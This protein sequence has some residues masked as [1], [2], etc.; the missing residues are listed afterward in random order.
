MPLIKL[1]Y[2][3]DNKDDKG[4]DDSQAWQSFANR[5]PKPEV[6]AMENDTP[7]KN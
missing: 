7:V 5:L 6:L 3:T 2:F 1:I 4:D